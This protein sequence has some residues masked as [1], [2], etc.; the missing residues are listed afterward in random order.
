M[1]GVCAMYE[2]YERLRVEHRPDGLLLVSIPA[3]QPGQAANRQLHHELRRV[4]RDIGDD[5]DVRA[6][7]L[8]GDGPVFM[9]S[10]TQG[11]RGAIACQ[12]PAAKAAAIASIG[13]SS[14]G[15]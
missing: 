4:W 15:A 8:T 14:L 7:V 9:P 11:A 12:S 1:K 5:P 13:A 2:K 10:V 6:A 3:R